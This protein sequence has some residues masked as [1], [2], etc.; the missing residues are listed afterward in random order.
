MIGKTLGHYTIL[1]ALGAGG[2]GQV[3]RAVDTNLKRD[4]AVKVLPADLND[5]AERLARLER[6]AYA[7][8]SMNHPNIATIHGL[9]QQDDV[10][11]LV[12]ELV[13]GQTLEQRLRFGALP[14]NEA[15]EIG[16]QIAE[17][18]EAAHDNGIVHRDL[19][20]ANVM[21]GSRGHV[22]VLDFGLAKSFDRKAVT[23]LHTA[24]TD[25]AELAGGTD[26]ADSA[27]THLTAAGT[28]VGT[29][30]YMS[31]EQI[32]ADELDK[33]CDN[34]AFGCVL[35]EMLTGRRAFDRSSIGDTLAAVLEHEPAWDRLP[36]DTPDSIRSLLAR[37]LEKDPGRRVH[38]IADAR[39]E[40]DNML[41][42]LSGAS[43]PALLRPEPGRP[44]WMSPSLALAAAAGVLVL[45]LVALN[46]AGLR[47]RAAA[48]LGAPAGGAAADAIA[49]LVV[50]PLENFS[51]DPD[52][53]YFVDG[54]TD[55]LITDLSKVGSL[56]VLSRTTAM[57][58][59][60]TDKTLPQIAQELG[61]DAVV[62]G[63]IVRDGERVR[64]NAQLID[65]ATDTQI[66]SDTFERELTSILALQADVA[67]AVAGATKV[68]VTPEEETRLV[69]DR[70]VDPE[71]YQAYL[72]G[73]YWLNKG[74]PEGITTGMAFLRE[75]VEK[76][77]GDALA[78]AGLAIGFI[79]VAHGPAP[80]ADAL[81]QAK[82]AAQ[83]AVRLDDTLG[84]AH[85]SLAFIQ[86]Y[87]DWE[88]ELAQE[89][90]DH[91]L[92]INASLAIAHYHDSWFHAL[93]GRMEE[94]IEAHKRA[95]ELD[96]LMPL[97]TAWLGGLYQMEGRYEEAIAEAE[98][99]IEIAPGFP[100]GHYVLA[101]V[102]EDQGRYEAAFEAFE[103][104][105]ALAPPW[106]WALGPAYARAGRTD[107]ARG[108]LAEL[109]AQ[110]LTPWNAMWLAQIHTALGNKDEAFR[111]LNYERP[112]AW[113]PWVRMLPWFE[114][115]RDDPRFDDLLRRMNLPPRE[116]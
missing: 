39:I 72:R 91:A 73:M 25:V 3:Y 22:K 111:W 76:D 84:E 46:V 88:W 65:A 103:R 33:R 104:A 71:S 96:P 107:E 13:D 45:A 60:G 7:L 115:L 108:L 85:A 53:E 6:E 49:S 16:R 37:C 95:Q 78:Y 29:A 56:R 43:S 27:D 48:L 80:P 74:T 67:R 70:D 11:Y 102:Y 109:E 9:E 94:A 63:S 81:S 57:R 64:I 112:H 75:A 89:T 42:T 114:P 26:V 99:S 21:I 83:K 98:R 106:K 90:I 12:L 17:A 18:L 41:R 24:V 35:F 5:D 66:W 58:Y 77:P 44:A 14:F 31:P 47:D 23:S 97:H 100:I 87:Y 8:A 19:K 38:D 92:E 36:S 59:K 10:R 15:L 34:W 62:E 20:P 101:T 105:A 93:F 50:L 68:R 54:M 51:A 82:S 4:V 52:Q 69:G 116:G 55:A 2:M 113:I 40:I 86:G 30:P 32:R 79:T 28:V 110:L 1:E 61:V